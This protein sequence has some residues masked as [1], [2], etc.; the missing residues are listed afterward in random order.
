MSYIISLSI[1]STKD[2]LFHTLYSDKHLT[3]LQKLIDISKAGAPILRVTF[4]S[5]HIP[6]LKVLRDITSHLAQLSHLNSKYLI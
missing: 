2:N 5:N 6:E 1:L 3:L 4:L